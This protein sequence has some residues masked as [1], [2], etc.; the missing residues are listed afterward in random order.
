[1]RER[2]IYQQL[3]ADGREGVD[4]EAT[5]RTNMEEERLLDTLL[6][7]KLKFSLLGVDQIRHGSHLKG[8][9]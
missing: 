6:L 8:R 5:R 2:T 3:K 7:Q 1:M 4:A 9:R